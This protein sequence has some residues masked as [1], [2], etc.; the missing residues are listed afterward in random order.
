MSRPGSSPS[1]RTPTCAAT[2]RAAS[3]TRSRTAT[4]GRTRP[5]SPST[6]P[7]STTTR[8]RSTTPPRAPRTPDVVIAGADLVA[9]RHRHR[10]RHAST[11]RR[12][13]PERRHRLAR[14]RRRD[15]HPHADLCGT[16]PA[17]TTRSSDGNGGT[18]NGH[19]TI[20]LACTSDDPVADDDTV[21]VAEDSTDTDVTAGLLANDT[22]A[23]GDT[24]TVTDVSNATG[25]TVDLIAGAVT[26]TPDADLCGDGDGG[27]DYTVATARRHR[28][29][30]TPRST[31]PASTTARRRRRH[32]SGTEDTDVVIDAATWSATTPTSRAT[33]SPSAACRNPTGGD[34]RPRRRHDHLHARRQRCA[35]TTRPASTTRSTTATAAPTPA[36]VTID[37]SA[38][39]TTRSPTTTRDSGTEDTDVVVDA[40]DLL[41]NDTDVDGDTLAVTGVSNP[42][43]DRRSRRQHGHFTPDADLCGTRRRG[44][45]YAISDGNGGTDTA[46]VTVD[47]SCV[48]DNPVAV[49][50]DPGHR[51]HRRPRDRG[52]LLV[53][54]HRRRGRHP[55]RHRRLEP[56]GGTVR[57]MAATIT[58]TPDADLCGDGGGGFDYTVSDGNGGTDTGHVIVDLACAN[59][60]PVADD[61]TVMVDENRAPTTSP[62][63][64]LGNDSDIDP[65][66]RSASTASANPTGGTV[67]LTAGVVTFTPAA[68][69][70]G[71]GEGGFDYTISDGNGGIDTG[72]RHRRHQLR[73]QRCPVAVDDLATRHRGHRRRHRRRDPGR[74]RHRHRSG[75]TL[76]VTAVTTPRAGRS[77][78]AATPSRSPPTPT[79]AARRRRLRLHGRATATAAATRARHIWHHL[80][81][82]RPGGRR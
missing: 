42:R 13:E 20:D 25:G 30:A 15:L 53:Q 22:D 80:R 55:R 33:R 77:T 27:F 56:R 49:D 5:A 44:F 39:T 59:D 65:A 6:S 28:H 66:T 21:T 38:T 63:T 10:G 50:D 16:P 2:A 75:D 47:I 58:F 7:A 4:A 76:T 29:G 54:R 23:D 8:T 43:R 14:S 79:C 45:D 52:G 31:S 48:N 9:Q 73:G 78:S 3:T 68:D 34:G 67:D 41:A 72:P 74:Q 24:L 61:D 1:R 19:V 69:L 82:R 26:F 32:A 40:A 81:Q 18:D 36:T 17:S 11:Y 64:I 37:L 62:P 35:A 71:N 12:L 70:C 51:G 60:A 46:T 57:S